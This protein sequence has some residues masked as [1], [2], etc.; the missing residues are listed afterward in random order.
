MQLMAWFSFFPP[1]SFIPCHSAWWWSFSNLIPNLDSF[2]LLLLSL[3][4]GHR[5]SSFHHHHQV[6]QHLF[7]F[8]NVVV[9]LW[10]VTNTNLFISLQLKFSISIGCLFM[11]LCVPHFAWDCS[12][13]CSSLRF[14]SCCSHNHHHHHHDIRYA[15]I[16]RFDCCWLCNRAIVLWLLLWFQVVVLIQ[17]DFS[18]LSIPA[19]IDV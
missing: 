7:L 15:N 3:H 17:F 1:Y 12:S 8:V 6:C 16:F 18:S 9:L 13:Q 10:L 14:S 5:S 4:C 11:R 2:S 19:N